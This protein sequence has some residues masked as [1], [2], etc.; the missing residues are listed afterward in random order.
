MVEKKILGVLGNKIDCHL[1]RL[2]RV[3]L[4]RE[5]NKSNIFKILKKLISQGFYIQKN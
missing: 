5:K 4:K 3:T 1:I 2:L